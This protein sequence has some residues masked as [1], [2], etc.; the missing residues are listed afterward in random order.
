MKQPTI[1]KNLIAKHAER[2]QKRQQLKQEKMDNKPIYQI[3]DLYIGSIIQIEKE[4]YTG[5][6]DT[7]HWQFIPLKMHAILYHNQELPYDCYKH[8]AS[9]YIL[10]NQY[11]AEQGECAIRRDS[12]K[13]LYRCCPNYIIG[14]NLTETSKLSK[15][16]IIELEKVLNFGY[17]YEN[18][19]F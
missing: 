8:V 14:N 17:E 11:N 6:N 15:N 9:D 1:I 4:W 3:K 7:V 16:Q 12:T 10:K 2:K 19:P 13:S 5:Y 18:S